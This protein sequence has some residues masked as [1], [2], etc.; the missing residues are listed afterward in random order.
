[1]RFN[2]FNARKRK[3]LV[4]WFE[5]LQDDVQ[6]TIIPIFLSLA[7]IMTGNDVSL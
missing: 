7:L 4:L 1:M 3:G 5:W 6:D 2:H